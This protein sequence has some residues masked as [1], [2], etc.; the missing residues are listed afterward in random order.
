MK[1]KLKYSESQLQKA[2][3]H[4]LA[5]TKNI[6]YIRNNSYAGRIIGNDGKTWY[7]RNN[8]KGS[9]DI[10]LLKNGFW[11]GLE[12]KTEE[13]R[14]SPEQKQAEKDIRKA[15]GHYFIIRSLEELEAVLE[16]F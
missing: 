5:W 1:P 7:M 4:R 13:G 3:L 10:I 15:G 6:Y 2:I 14:Q 8:K 11:L 16:S 9:P 12:I